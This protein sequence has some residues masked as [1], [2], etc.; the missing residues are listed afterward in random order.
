MT[1]SSSGFPPHPRTSF[2]RRLEPCQVASGGR[3]RLRTDSTALAVR[4][5][6]PSPPS[7]NNMH[8]FGQTGV[9]LYSDGAY[10]GT[11]IADKDAQ[12]GKVYE[13]VYFGASPRAWREVTLYLSLYK[14]G[15]SH[16]CRN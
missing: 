7:M 11:A 2:R 15:E 10:R 14:P 4:L 5:E 6:Y 1:A 9:D 13:H 16:L 3:I 8:A 12:P